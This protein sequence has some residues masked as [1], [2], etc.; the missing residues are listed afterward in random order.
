MSFPSSPSPPPPLPSPVLVPTPLPSPPPCARKLL[1]PFV[2]KTLPHH[3]L[4]RASSA[5]RIRADNTPIRTIK[6]TLSHIPSR[7]RSPPPS[8]ATRSPP[9]PVPPMPAFVLTAN[10]SFSGRN[11]TLPSDL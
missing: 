10:Q 2:T 8:P 11:R 5:P 3:T 7:C 4:R 6:R 9:P 1:T